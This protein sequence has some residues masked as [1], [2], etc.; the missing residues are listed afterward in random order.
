MTDVITIHDHDHI[1]FDRPGKTL[2][3]VAFHYDGTWGNALVPLAV[4]NGTA[5]HARAGRVQGV[6]AFGGTHGNEYEGQVAVWRLMHELDPAQIS[7]RV[8][9]MPRLNWPACNSGTRESQVD[10]VNM[11]RAFPGNPLGSLTYRIAHFVN[12][13][14]FPLVEVV[15]DIH[16]GGS[17]IEFA[18][19][20]SFHLVKDPA[21][22]AEMKVVA[23]LFDTPY[24][25]IY[26]SGMA[27]GLLVDQAEA[28]GKITIGGEFGHSSGVHYRGVRHAYQ[29][30]K[31]VLHHYKLLPGAIERV[32]PERPTPPRL[33]EA[34]DLEDYVP[35]PVT[36]VFEP[37]YA[38]GTPV[39]AGQ[40]VGHLYDFERVGDAPLAIHAPSDGYIIL[41][42]FQAPVAKGDTMLV[43]GKDVRD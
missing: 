42:P 15:L 35:A 4:I 6:A 31:N 28:L 29:G 24:V 33:V 13:R 23:S 18:L 10:G 14:V 41:Q 2:Y 43:I 20:T 37:E 25:Y 22:Y 12:T 27:R 38:V 1:D 40:L 36:G 17:T 39:T 26:S 9:L 8:I 34:V 19:C 11:N 30:I 7:G 16:A 32:A 21:Q 3:E 5:G